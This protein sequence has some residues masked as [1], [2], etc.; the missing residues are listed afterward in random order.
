MAITKC[1]RLFK[2]KKLYKVVWPCLTLTVQWTSLQM[3]I[4]SLPLACVTH[5]FLYIAGHTMAQLVL[6]PPDIIGCTKGIIVRLCLRRQDEDRGNFPLAPVYLEHAHGGGGEDWQETHHVTV[7]LH[8]LLFRQ[9]RQVWDSVLTPQYV[10][11][12]LT[13]S[14]YSWAFFLLP[15]FCAHSSWANMIEWMPLKITE[16]T[17]FWM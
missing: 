6:P 17:V 8:N 3:T 15:M 13:G 12:S 4:I 10:T 9:S 16:Q 1:R 11:I 5:V 14:S 7:C 2:I